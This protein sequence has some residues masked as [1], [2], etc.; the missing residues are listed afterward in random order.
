MNSIAGWRMRKGRMYTALAAV[1]LLPLA[2]GGTAP[3]QSI[4]GVWAL[5]S[6]TDNGV[7]G[8]TTGTVTFNDDGTW[9]V[10]GTVTYPGEPTDSL[11]VNGTYS[12]A[13]DKLTLTIGDTTGVW[14]IT[15]GSLH[16]T[17]VLQPPDQP[18][19]ME[20]GRLTL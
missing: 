17:L 20:L 7:V 8:A 13:G 6:F 2:C 19:V 1:A 3:E 5:E 9:S 18:N 15:W 12:L 11:V 10:V 4:L 14:A 16:V